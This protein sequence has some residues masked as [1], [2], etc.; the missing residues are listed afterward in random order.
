ML[1]QE[2]VPEIFACLTSPLA[3]RTNPGNTVGILLT[4]VT[5]LK[6]DSTLLSSMEPGSIILRSWIPNTNITENLSDSLTIYDAGDKQGFLVEESTGKTKWFVFQVN[7]RL[8]QEDQSILEC[9]DVLHETAAPL[10]Y[11]S[12]ERYP[13][14][15]QIIQG[16]N[17]LWTLP[18]SQILITR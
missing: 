11:F 13:L 15:Q 6:I 1:R 12:I 10:H 17:M 8:L 14:K 2:D 9:C 4:Q 5:T 3:V 18:S 16:K 7:Y